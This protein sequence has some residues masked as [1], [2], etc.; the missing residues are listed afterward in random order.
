MKNIPIL[1]NSEMVN[2]ILQGKKTQTR[3]KVKMPS[4]YEHIGYAYTNHSLD[5]IKVVVMEEDDTED[6]EEIY[7]IIEP[8]AKKGDVFW[9]REGWT[10]ESSYDAT[11]PSLIPKDAL[12]F[13]IADEEWD[14]YALPGKK[15]PSIFMPKW[16]CRLF[17]EVTDVRLE[18]L[19]GISQED[20]KGEG[21]KSRHLNKGSGK[22]FKRYFNYF[23]NDYTCL[24]SILSFKTLW[25]SIYGEGSWAE[26]PYV[27]VYEFKIIEKPENFGK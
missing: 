6:G 27:W 18:R 15:R 25:Q 5:H 19:D 12:I 3:R 10:T 21:I 4:Q 2:A 26:N 11:K 13:Y 17:L 16:V 22:I 24:S 8:K 1:L 23:T 14:Y 20:A 7:I 9:V